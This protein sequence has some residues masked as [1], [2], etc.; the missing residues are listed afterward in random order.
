MVNTKSRR[1]C[2]T[3]PP[4]CCYNWSPP[5]SPAFRLHSNTLFP[6]CTRAPEALISYGWPISS[7]SLTHISWLPPNALLLH[8]SPLNLPYDTYSLPQPYRTLS[9]PSVTIPAHPSHRACCTMPPQPYQIPSGPIS[10]HP[11]HRAHRTM[12]VANLHLIG[13]QSQTPSITIAAHSGP[14]SLPHDIYSLPPPYRIPS[15]AIT[16]RPQTLPCSMH[17]PH[18]SDLS[19]HVTANRSHL[20]HANLNPHSSDCI[21]CSITM[22]RPRQPSLH[23][24]H[25]PPPSADTFHASRTTPAPWH[26]LPLP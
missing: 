15:V 10:H 16:A 24:L 7:F 8:L 19:E 23:L 17:P 5:L 12:S 26:M 25:P 14:S 6:T 9:E 13:F 21:P 4:F 22:C 1:L 11:S 3:Q 18:A 2:P 20:F